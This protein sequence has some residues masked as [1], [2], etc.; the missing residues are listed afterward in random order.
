MS[1]GVSL[2]RVGREVGVSYETV[3]KWAIRHGWERRISNPLTDGELGN[4][5]LD[6]RG[7]L[8]I[9]APWH[10]NADP[11]GMVSLAR[12]VMSQTLDRPLKPWEFVRHADGDVLNCAPENLYIEVVVFPRYREAFRKEALQRGNETTGTGNGPVAGDN[13]ET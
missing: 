6:A 11:R 12:Y 7:R 13:P 4:I 9:R 1:Q 3:R 8:E 5:R 2:R 10:A